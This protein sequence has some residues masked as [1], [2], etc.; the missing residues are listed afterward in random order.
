MNICR[1]LFTLFPLCFSL[2]LAHADE[3]HLSGGTVIRCRVERVTSGEILYRDIRPEGKGGD[4]ASAPESKDR[5]TLRSINRG[6]AEMIVYDDGEVLTLK[7]AAGTDRIFL[8]NGRI[9]QGKVVHVSDRYLVYRPRGQGADQVIAGTV[10]RKVLFSDNTER[11]MDGLPQ[12]I[13]AGM[14]TAEQGE[15]KGMAWPESGTPKR[16][17]LGFGL[18]YETWR[19]VWKRRHVDSMM[20]GR[21]VKDLHVA[22]AISYLPS[23]SVRLHERLWGTASFCYSKHR[24]TDTM[25]YTGGSWQCATRADG[26]IETYRAD[27]DLKWATG[28]WLSV[29]G[30]IFYF[31]YHHNMFNRL[32]VVSSPGYADASEKT[33]LNS[34]GARIGPSINLPIIRY[35]DFQ[36]RLSGGY[37]LGKESYCYD[38]A[39]TIPY[40]NSISSAVGAFSIDLFAGPEFKIPPLQTTIILGFNCELLWY[41]QH[42]NFYYHSGRRDWRYGAVCLLRYTF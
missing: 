4:A 9:L 35:L 32:V 30:G 18:G 28:R 41:T 5:E 27:I 10:V 21:G 42:E 6:L 29:H 37:L 23:I 1:Y 22:P 3:I 33:R 36:A 38:R 11:V 34:G 16:I 39:L 12:D 20:T 15:R 40:A 25:S 31:G 8:Y 2:C 14:E 7:A 17:S 13:A 26:Y 24:T 19:P